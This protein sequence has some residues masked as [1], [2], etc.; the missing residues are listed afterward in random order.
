MTNVHVN[1]LVKWCSISFGS[2]EANPLSNAHSLYLDDKEVTALVVPDGIT[3]IRKYAFSGCRSLVSVMMLDDV[4]SVEEY[5]FEG[6]VNLIDALICTSSCCKFSVGA[7]NGCINL[8]GVRFFDR[9]TGVIKSVAVDALEYKPVRR[10]C[11]HNNYDDDW[12]PAPDWREESG[13]NDVYGRGV[14]ASD[15]LDFGD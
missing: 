7:F 3:C 8:K 4:K 11:H 13:W 5:A 1:D 9:K 12:Y 15:I 14:E 2:L 6:C 10:N